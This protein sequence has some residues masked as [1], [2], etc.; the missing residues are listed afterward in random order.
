MLTIDFRKKEVHPAP[1]PPNEDFTTLILIENISVWSRK[2]SNPSNI[3]LSCISY[4]IRLGRRVCVNLGVI[5][6]SFIP[7]GLIQAGDCHDT[8]LS[9]PSINLFLR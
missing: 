5:F 7:F 9:S 6:I 1:P 3:P 2:D 8:C 4:Y